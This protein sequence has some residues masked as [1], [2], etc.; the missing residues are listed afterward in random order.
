MVFQN[1]LTGLSFSYRSVRRCLLEGIFPEQ[2][3]S[4]QAVSGREL[5]RD[6]FIVKYVVIM[7]GISQNP[8]KSEEGFT[9]KVECFIVL[10]T[11]GVTFS[12]LFLAEF[13]GSVL[14][15]FP[16]PTH[17]PE[18]SS[19]IIIC[20]AEAA[21]LKACV[22]KYFYSQSFS[23]NEER[24]SPD[25]PGSFLIIQSDDHPTIYSS[26]LKLLTQMEFPQVQ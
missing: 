10:H 24:V 25:A 12:F 1:Y 17:T 23:T 3:S 4:L 13:S 15:F 6:C 26:S 8:N 20:M 9:F 5:S 19:R 2:K 11:Y 16:T 7:L 14:L 21:T 18:V 22:S